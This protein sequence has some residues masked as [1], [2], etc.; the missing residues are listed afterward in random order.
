[1]RACRPT[2]MMMVPRILNMA[3]ETYKLKR[4]ALL[5][6]AGPEGGDGA[7]IVESE[8]DDPAKRALIARLDRQAR[9]YV[10]DEVFGG[11]LLFQL[12]GSAPS[13]PE[14]MDCIRDCNGVP[15]VEGY[16]STGTCVRADRMSRS[17]GACA[18][19]QD[20][21][22]S[23][24]CTTQT[25]TELG[26]ITIDNHISP[27]TVLAWK[28]VDAPELGYTA[29]DQPFPRGELLVKT[30]TAI[31]GYYKNA[32]VRPSVCVVVASLFGLVWIGG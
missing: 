29:R 30:N 18:I 22:P 3:Y 6:A 17:V 23:N 14:V 19:K 11:R 5:A 15:F 24:T 27:R 25:T 10:R 16:G 32:K 8:D 28:L 9:D 20:G 2:S 7:G 1:M 4:A 31:P 21:P 12:V 26:G 13:S